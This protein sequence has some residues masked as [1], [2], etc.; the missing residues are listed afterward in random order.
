MV[1]EGRRVQFPVTMNSAGYIIVAKGVPPS[2]LLL[3]ASLMGFRDSGMGSFAGDEQKEEKQGL[4]WVTLCVV[5]G[6]VACIQPAM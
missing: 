3:R 1:L 6:M 4:A 2:H 5:C